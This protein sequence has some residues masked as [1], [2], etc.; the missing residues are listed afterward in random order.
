MLEPNKVGWA[1]DQK[2]DAK[3]YLGTWRMVAV[4]VGGKDLSPGSSTL[5]IVTGDGWTVTTN[6]DVYQSWQWPY[7][8]HL[9]SR[10]VA[11]K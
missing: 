11:S 10:K 5:N 8:I 6:G 3:P 2:P 1:D 4:I 7:S 9:D